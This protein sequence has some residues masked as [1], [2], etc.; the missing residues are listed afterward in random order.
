MVHTRIDRRL[1][2]F[3][4]TDNQRFLFAGK[5][6]EP[7]KATKEPMKPKVESVKPKKDESPKKN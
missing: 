3:L 6:N 2:I 7:V 1:Y 5:A 4:C